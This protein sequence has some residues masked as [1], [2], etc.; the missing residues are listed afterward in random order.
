MTNEQ[1]AIVVRALQGDLYWGHAL[2][3][4]MISYT[5]RDALI[6][7]FTAGWCA[8]WWRDFQ[9]WRKNN[10]VQFWYEG[11]ASKSPTPKVNPDE[12][13]TFMSKL[14]EIRGSA[15]QLGA[16][17]IGIVGAVA[18]LVASGAAAVDVVEIWITPNVWAAEYLAKL[19]R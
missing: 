19:L 14:A 6:I 13:R 15:S 8:F 10:L 9:D 17:G 4:A 2:T 18:G 11:A 16:A 1:M 5:I 12:L 3:Q 7:V